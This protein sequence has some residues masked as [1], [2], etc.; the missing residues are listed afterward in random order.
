MSENKAP[1]YEPW[2]RGTLVEVPAIPRAVVHS[3]QLAGEDLHMWCSFLTDEQCNARPAGLA[4]VSFHVRHI[5]R[6]LD[7][8]LTYGEGSQLNQAQLLDLR[9]ELDPGATRESLFT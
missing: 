9:S 7:R 8:L 3:L 2:L 1:S 5:A 6:S 4:P